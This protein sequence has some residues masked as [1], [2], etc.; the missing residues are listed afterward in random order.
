MLFVVLVFLYICSILADFISPYS[1]YSSNK[2]LSYAPPSNI[3]ILDKTNK[4]TFPYTYNYKRMF[5]ESKFKVDYIEDTS[6]AYKLKLF[7]KGDEYKFLGIKQACI[8]LVQ[9]MAGSFF[10]WGQT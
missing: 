4:L 6:K 5:N 7:V 9:Q 10:F 8:C 1:A 3:Y 2:E